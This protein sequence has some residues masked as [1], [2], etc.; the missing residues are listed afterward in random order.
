M[1]LTSLSNESLLAK[2]IHLTSEER[3]ITIEV[4]WCLREVE[5]RL[6]FAELGF[7]SVYEFCIQKLGYSEGSAHRRIS[8]MRLLREL[9]PEIQ[10]QTEEKIKSGILSV[11]N[12]S[13]VHG[14][15]K[16]EKKLENK[17]YSAAEKSDLIQSIEGV[18]KKNAEKILGDLQPAIIPQEKERV[19]NSAQTEIKFIASVELMAK[20]N[21]IKERTAHSD[22]SPSYA[23]LFEKMADCMLNKIEARVSL[24][25]KKTGAV[26]EP[27]LED[28]GKNSN[29]L[30]KKFVQNSSA[31][32]EFEPSEPA[33]H[34]SI[35]SESIGSES[36]QN[37]SKQSTSTPIAFTPITSTHIEYLQSTFHVTS[38]ARSRSRY[39]SAAVRKEVWQRDQGTCT[40]FHEE[41]EKKCTSRFGLE[42]DHV[43]PFAFGGENTA[44]NL[45]LRCRAHN[46]LE[47]QKLGIRKTA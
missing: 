43:K 46:L 22:P 28:V 34:E 26:A 3:R 36:K 23:T 30:P 4:L 35:G 9:P 27:F 31:Q 19:L 42:L 12:L 38:L 1:N 2:T 41:P 33:H 29:S 44:E 40:Y 13:L 15:L 17:S 7:S 6:L 37:E 20:L 16:L 18:S 5:S 21:R 24:Q 11:T 47:A 39:I 8:A 10:M 25:E 32:K 45:R 14:F